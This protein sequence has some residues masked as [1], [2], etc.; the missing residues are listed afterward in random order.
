MSVLIT[1]ASVHGSTK[2]IAE[3]VGAV[4][5]TY[6]GDSNIAVHVLPMEQ[7]KDISKY[8]FIIIG[9]AVHNFEWVPLGSSWL[10]RNK[11]AVSKV[12][13]WAFSVGTPFAIGKIGQR[14]LESKDEERKLVEAIEANVHI[15][16]HTLFNGKV[17]TSHTPTLF[18]MWWRLFGGKF[19][20]FRDWDTIDNW[21]KEVGDQILQKVRG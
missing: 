5:S 8:N 7:A 17:L 12:P 2:E 19:G 4:L 1:Y 16:S 3:R 10:S 14:M 18:N 15:E 11:S 21:A 6:L 20:D 9:S 13:V